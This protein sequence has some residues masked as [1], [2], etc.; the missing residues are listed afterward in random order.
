MLRNDL[1]S[2]F[3]KLDY[4]AWSSRARAVFDQCDKPFEHSAAIE[5]KRWVMYMLTEGYQYGQKTDH[6]AKLHRD[7]GRKIDEL[8]ERDVKYQELL[9]AMTQNNGRV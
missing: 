2:D 5:H 1:I 4:D 9:A 8:D 3:Y 6:V 7:I